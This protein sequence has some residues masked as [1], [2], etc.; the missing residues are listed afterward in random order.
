[1][2]LAQSNFFP[3]RPVH[4][5][6]DFV[7]GKGG[8]ILTEAKEGMKVYVWSANNEVYWGQGTITKVEELYIVD[9]DDDDHKELL[10]D[11]YPSEITLPNGRTTEGLECWWIPVEKVDLPDDY[12]EN[13][14]A[15][16]RPPK[17]QLKYKRCPRS[18]LKTDV[19]AKAPRKDCPFRSRVDGSC[20]LPSGYKYMKR[21]NRGLELSD[22]MVC[23]L[24][25]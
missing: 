19:P 1:M 16:W 14:N 15:I 24:D 4:R 11:N 9:D 5:I 12:W 22:K 2:D 25:S 17:R 18:F 10:T 20:I 7:E 13:S 23:Y 6:F 8:R 3:E 21:M